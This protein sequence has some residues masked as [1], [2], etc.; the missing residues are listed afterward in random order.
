[1]PLTEDQVGKLTVEFPQILNLSEMRDL[2]GNLSGSFSSP[3][4]EIDGTYSFSGEGLESLSNLDSGIYIRHFALHKPGNKGELIRLSLIHG[5]SLED[6]TRVY[7]GMRESTLELAPHM[8][9]LSY[10]SSGNREGFERASSLMAQ[11]RSVTEQ[12]FAER[13]AQDTLL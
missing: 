3:R 13:N 10:D 12:Y 4:V 6:R 9:D 1:M 5:V 11:I 2:I 8:Y 7:N